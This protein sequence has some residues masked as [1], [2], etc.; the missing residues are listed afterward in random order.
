MLSLGICA[1]MLPVVAYTASLDR[2]VVVVNDDIITESE[3]KGEIIRYRRELSQRNVQA[4]GQQTLARQTLERMIAD[5]VQLQV[6]ERAGIRVPE[7][8]ISRAVDLVARQNNLSVNELR[9]ALELDGLSF[10]EFRDQIEAE[11]IIRRLREREVN[12]KVVITE[13]EIRT[14]VDSGQS[15]ATLDVEY[16]L[17]HILLPADENMS[18]KNLQETRAQAENMVAEL[19]QGSDFAALA[20]QVSKSSEAPDGGALG[21]RKADQLPALFLNTI[22]DMEAG[23]VSDPLRSPNGFHILK[24]HERRGG[25]EQVIDQYRARHILL[26]PNEFLSEQEV[27]DRLERL[28]NR[29]ANGEGFEQ[30]ARVNSEDSASRVKG[31]DLGWITPGELEPAMERM[32]RSLQMNEV[33]QPFRTT[34]GLH[35]VQLTDKRS[36]QISGELDRESVRQRLYLRKANELYERW[37]RELLDQAYI[38]YRLDETG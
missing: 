11:L 12:S 6:A 32:I 24:L 38:E 8:S 2:V 7:E 28:R 33:S 3:L 21:W 19:R 22:G 35:I 26:K 1:W 30:L 13:D 23:E 15:P 5:R 29:I 10:Q 16:N 34:S 20:V 14:V 9:R 25:A 36:T 31:G 17:S 37:L 27:S 18:A 4:P